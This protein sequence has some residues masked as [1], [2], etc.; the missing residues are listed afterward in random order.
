M[1]PEYPNGT[2]AYFCTVDEDWNSAYPYAVETSF[3]GNVQAS[4]VN[5]VSETVE[6]YVST[7][8]LNDAFINELSFSVFPNLT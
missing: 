2:Y 5:S 7:N 6:V 4:D 8:G 1:T 3:Y